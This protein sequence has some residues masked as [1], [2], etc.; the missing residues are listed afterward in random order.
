[1]ATEYLDLDDA[2]DAYAE[3]VEVSVD[4]ARSAVVNP[5]HLESALA[6]PQN[7]A[8]YEGADIARQAATLFRALSR[9]TLFA[10]ATNVP[11]SSCC[12]HSST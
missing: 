6:R 7:A 12:A 4:Q 1:L 9:T 3:A 11:R 8:A 5:A 10:M 2:F